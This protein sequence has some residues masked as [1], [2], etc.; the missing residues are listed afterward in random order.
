[1]R[2]TV[3]AARVSL[4]GLYKTV[5]FFAG[6]TFSVRDCMTNYRLKQIT[7]HAARAA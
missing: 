5:L 4:F 2:V 1:M 6:V 3:H 7:H